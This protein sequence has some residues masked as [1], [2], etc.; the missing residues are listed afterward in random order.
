MGRKVKTVPTPRGSRRPWF[1]GLT[2]M[3]TPNGTSIGTSVFVGGVD[4]WEPKESSFCS[5]VFKCFFRV[6]KTFLVGL[7]TGRAVVL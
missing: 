7:A 1:L 4:S 6:F 3:E 2:T 5:R